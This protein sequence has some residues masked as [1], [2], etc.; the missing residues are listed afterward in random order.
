[1]TRYILSVSH[2]GAFK[3]QGPSS[4]GCLMPQ[5]CNHGPFSLIV[6]NAGKDKAY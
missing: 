1:M 3:L 2:F 5:R 6:Q 4:A